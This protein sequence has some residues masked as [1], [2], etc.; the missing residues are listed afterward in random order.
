MIGRLT[1]RP[2]TGASRLAPETVQ[3]S[4]MDCGPAT[5][6]CLVEGF[7]IRVSYDRLREA[8]QTDIDGTS[9]DAI[10]EAAGELGV[11]AEQIMIPS[12]HLLLPEAA[13]L[14]AI[15][16]VT[17][18]AGAT[19]FVVVWNRIGPRVQVMDPASGRRWSTV[20]ESPAGALHPR[21][22]RAGGGLAS[23]G[24]L[25]GVHPGPGRPDEAARSRP[26]GDH[27]SDLHRGELFR[28]AAFRHSRRGGSHGAFPGAIRSAA[29][30]HR[31][32]AF[33]RGLPRIQRVGSGAILVGARGRR[34]GERGRGA[35]WGRLSAW[36]R[37]AGSWTGRRWR[38]TMS[39]RASC[40]P[41]SSD[42]RAGPSRG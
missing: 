10:E 13:A 23:M 9:I 29:S 38:T 37:G 22:P 40:P 28:L 27:R 17:S 19:H 6:K 16:V 31:G 5:L 2:R 26:V 4:A 3:A 7:G 18:A 32:G 12:D 30:G 33:R 42:R 24:G 41:R 34:P 25:R 20:E 8:C 36:Y 11:A 1:L 14:P 15:V 39:V 35:P 21:D